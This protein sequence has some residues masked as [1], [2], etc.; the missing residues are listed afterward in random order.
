MG[1]VIVSAPTTVAVPPPKELSGHL[2]ALLTMVLWGQMV[3]GFVVL[4]AVWDPFALSAARYV[5]AAPIM[6]GALWIARGLELPRRDEV[7]R[8]AV[9]GLVGMGG[10]ITCYTY[11]LAHS[12]PVVAIIVQS[13]AP[14]TYT[15]V[16]TLAYREPVPTGLGSTLLLVIPGGLLLAAPALAGTA[17]TPRGGEVLLI[18]GSVCWAWYSLQC[19][20]W[21]PHY[22]EFRLTTWTIVAATPFLVALFFLLWSAGLTAPP[23][24]PPPMQLN[25]LLLWL[26]VSSSCVGIVLWHGSVRRLGVATA[27]LYFNVAPLVAMA[28]SAAL[29]YVP[30]LLQLAGGALVLSGV[31]QL[32]ARRWWAA[33]RRERTAHR[34]DHPRGPLP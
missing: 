31:G 3:P 33:R 14:L 11:G 23:D 18:A 17:A 1:T 21:L 7:G 34:L 4:L 16:A 5:I 15:A 32:H 9:L 28:I 8:L 30:T 24:R 27:G 22:E 13:A 10:L 6:V 29:G 2:R 25:A 19:R 12:D 26:T 20:R